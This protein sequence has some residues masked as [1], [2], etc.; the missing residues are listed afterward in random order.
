MYGGGGTKIGG[1]RI[2]Y[3]TGVVPAGLRRVVAFGVIPELSEH[4][5]AEDH[6]ETGQG[7]VDVGVLVTGPPSRVHRL[8]L[9]H[10]RRAREGLRL[11]A[12]L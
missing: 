10:R 5:G 3:D 7:T 2:H 9:I 4:P 1:Y 6:T 11:G 12:P 8:S